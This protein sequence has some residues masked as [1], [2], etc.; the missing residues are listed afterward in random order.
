MD[1]P[2]PEATHLLGVALGR[3]LLAGSVLLLQGD[4]G[5]GK[6]TLVQGIGEGLGI[7]DP[8][9]SPTFILLNEYSEG[10]IPLYHFDL[11][12]LESAEVDALQLDLYW[13][14]SEY[15]LG[16][17]AIEWA[18]RLHHKPANYLHIGLTHLDGGDRQ[19][20][21]IP[22]GKFPGDVFKDN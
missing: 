16:I 7:P 19:A 1:L 21:F 11:Y 5:S 20:H 14:G 2:T 18:E 4:L 10:R 17:V 8:I 3:S 13:E 15:P 6:T 12:R 9:V 22:V